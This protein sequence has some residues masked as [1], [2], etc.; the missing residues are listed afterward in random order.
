MHHNLQSNLAYLM[1]VTLYK[2]LD[3]YLQAGSSRCVEKILDKTI[4]SINETCA[5]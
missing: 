2:K 5:G 1:L 3:G 4:K